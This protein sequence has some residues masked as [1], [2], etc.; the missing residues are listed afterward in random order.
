MAPVLRRPPVGTG[1]GPG[2]GSGYPG[3]TPPPG[4]RRGW[5]PAGQGHRR[6]DEL[7]YTS[8]CTFRSGPV[9]RTRRNFFDWRLTMAEPPRRSPKT[10]RRPLTE[11][12]DMPRLT[13]FVALLFSPALSADDK[14][15]PEQPEPSR[16]EV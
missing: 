1:T 14:P 10:F 8:S 2:G 6:V 7:L 5:K 15:A 9:K 3:P 4:E 16:Y 13:L 12:P 11:V